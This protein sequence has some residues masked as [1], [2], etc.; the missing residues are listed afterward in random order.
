[1]ST[2]ADN[3]PDP[4]QLIEADRWSGEVVETGTVTF[5][6]GTHTVP[7]R[8]QVF[9]DGSGNVQVAAPR[10]PPLSAVEIVADGLASD[11]K[12]DR[13]VAAVLA[14]NWEIDNE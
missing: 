2:Q 1:M 10:S 5:A 12:A 11:T 6:W 9:A 7:A 4:P 14:D 3:P 13:A 8:V